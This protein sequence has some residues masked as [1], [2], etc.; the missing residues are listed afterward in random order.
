MTRVSATTATV[1]VHNVQ[2]EPEGPFELM[3]TLSLVGP[4]I[5]SELT[6]SETGLSDVINALS[7]AHFECSEQG[8]R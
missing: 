2:R 4:A 8:R 7:A 5:T 3:A 6:L 1:S